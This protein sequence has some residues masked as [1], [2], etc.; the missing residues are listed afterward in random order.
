MKGESC[1]IG[2]YKSCFRTLD[3]LP[4]P[5]PHPRSHL[6]RHYEFTIA[7]TTVWDAPQQ[8]PNN[9]KRYVKVAPL[10]LIIHSRYRY[11]STFVFAALPHYLDISLG[12]SQFNISSLLSVP[13]RL[14]Y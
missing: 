14:F 13:H 9:E 8:N 4:R 6:H 12:G 1:W 7:S 11:L 3:T 5:H 10:N 2:S